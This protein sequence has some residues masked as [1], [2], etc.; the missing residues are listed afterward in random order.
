M[1]DW[2]CE[3]FAELDALIA[4]EK[5]VEAEKSVTRAMRKRQARWARM[6]RRYP[7]YRINFRRECALR[8]RGEERLIR[9]GVPDSFFEE[10]KGKRDA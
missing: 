9:A 5:L 7:A 1:D 4:A 8:R 3:R 10:R 6:R 2:R